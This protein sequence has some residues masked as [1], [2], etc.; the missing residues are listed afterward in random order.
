M[1]W[2]GRYVVEKGV[3]M[4]G[5]GKTFIVPSWVNVGDGWPFGLGPL[6]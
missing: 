4:A 2:R 3:V 5:R 1:W 6:G